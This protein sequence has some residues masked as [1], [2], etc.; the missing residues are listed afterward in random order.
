MIPETFIDSAFDSKVAE[1]FARRLLNVHKSRA[2]CVIVSVVH[3]TGLFDVLLE[4]PPAT[5]EQVAAGGR[6]A[7]ELRARAARGDGGAGPQKHIS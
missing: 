2:L 4:L 5:S 6:I 1:A 7:G 3:R